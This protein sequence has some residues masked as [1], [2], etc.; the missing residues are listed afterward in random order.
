[1]VIGRSEDR[2]NPRNPLVLRHHCSVWNPIRVTHLGQL[3]TDRTAKAG[4]MTA[5]DQTIAAAQPLQAGGRP[6]M[7][8]GLRACQEIANCLDQHCAS[9]ETAAARPPQD[10]E[11]SQFYQRLPHAEERPT[12]ASRSTHRRDAANFLTASFAG[13]TSRG[14]EA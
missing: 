8:P 1:M 12:G 6:H 4:H 7:D 13:E 11:L 14:A 5:T 9:F 2:D 3:S 10:E